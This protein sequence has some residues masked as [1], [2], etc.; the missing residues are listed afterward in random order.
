MAAASTM[1]GLAIVLGSTATLATAGAFTA[2]IGSPRVLVYFAASNL[3]A[4]ALAA[5]GVGKR[6]ADSVPVTAL[7][8][9]QG[10]R[11][12]L[13]LVLHSWYEQ[14]TLP[15]QMTYEGDNWDIVTGVLALA[16]ATASPKVAPRRQWWLAAGF[17]AVGMALLLRVMS[18]A[19]RSLPWQWRS[20]L[21]DP[22]VLLPFHAPYTWILPMCV[23]TALFGHLVVVRWLWARRGAVAG[24][25]V[26]QPAPRS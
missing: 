25:T 8:A 6:F 7:I 26:G 14:G 2:T 10:F 16:V 13:E 9:F 11:L 20:Y 18:I 12:P 1:S 17:T 21:G 19:L 23:S 3:T 4:I 22:P 15:V 5:S 24:A